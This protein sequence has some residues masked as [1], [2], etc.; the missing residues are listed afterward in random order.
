MHA[1]LPLFGFFLSGIA[2]S[3]ETTLSI[4][5]VSFNVDV[6]VT[7]QER[8]RGLMGRDSLPEKSGMLFVYN[9]PG[10]ISFWMK[11][12]LIPLD[13]LFFDKEGTLQEIILGARPCAKT[14]CQTYTNKKP[15]QFVLELPAGTVKK[16]NISIGNSFDTLHQ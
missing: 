7:Q 15:A 14:P 9:A 6:A 13:I 10:I 1:L 16:Y 8:N 4:N 11:N 3:G 12:T 2:Y 5:G